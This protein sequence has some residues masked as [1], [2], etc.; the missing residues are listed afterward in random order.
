LTIFSVS[1]PAFVY[2]E[3]LGLGPQPGIT[4]RDP[5]DVIRVDDTYYVWYTRTDRGPSGYDATVWYATSLDGHT[6][7]EQGEAVARGAPGEWDEQSA[8]TPGILLAD[9]VYYLFYTSVDRPF[10][11]AAHTAIGAAVA[12]SPHGPWVKLEG[13]PVL[14]PGPV[15]RFDSHRVDDSCLIARGGEYWLYYKGRQMGLSPAETKMGLAIARDPAGP[16]VKV[17]SDPVIP[18]GHEVLVWPHG[19]GVACLVSM[20]PKS[21]WYAEDGIEFGMVCELSDRPS[22]PGAYRPDA[23]DG[24][25]RGQGICWGICQ[26]CPPD[27]RPYLARFDCDLTPGH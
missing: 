17:S 5:S 21:L 23:F 18:C 22:A 14:E 25:T 3:A 12:D 27:A 15:E 9:E 1:E 13:N 26:V 20:G 11:E 6:W 4:R 10:S 24:P 19:P 8:F 7:S 16:Y 2:T